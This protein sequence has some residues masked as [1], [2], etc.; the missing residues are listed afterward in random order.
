MQYVNFD[1]K[2]VFSFLKST[3]GLQ[4][5]CVRVSF[6]YEPD[7]ETCDFVLSAA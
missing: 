3:T 4:N 6:L 7:T 5:P 1:T 2:S